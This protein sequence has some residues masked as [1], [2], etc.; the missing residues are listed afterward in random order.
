MLKDNINLLVLEKQRMADQLVQNMMGRASV[1]A[2]G[3]N[4]SNPTPVAKADNGAVE[5]TS[6]AEYDTLPSGVYFIN[7]VDGK[8]RKKN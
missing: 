6:Q 1:G 2:G 3:A 5:I 4:Q 8:I 7:P